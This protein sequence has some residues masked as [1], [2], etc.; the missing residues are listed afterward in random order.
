MLNSIPSSD[1]INV[2]ISDFKI[3]IVKMSLIGFLNAYYDIMS[4]HFLKNK[5][6][7]L[8]NHNS[9]QTQPSRMRR[10]VCSKINPS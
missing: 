1:F 3:I 5:T 10:N 7:C 9:E 2:K 6:F 4:C 8:K